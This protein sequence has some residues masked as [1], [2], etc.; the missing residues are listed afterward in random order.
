MK[1]GVVLEMRAEIKHCT[2]EDFY[3]TK[4]IKWSNVIYEIRFGELGYKIFGKERE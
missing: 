4:N 1:N 2:D 3:R